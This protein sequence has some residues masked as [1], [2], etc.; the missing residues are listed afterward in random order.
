[1][2][3]FDFSNPREPYD[4]RKKPLKMQEVFE[5]SKDYCLN[6]DDL[7]MRYNIFTTPPQDCKRGQYKEKQNIEKTLTHLSVRPNEVV[8]TT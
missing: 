1:M 2:N 4:I 8:I 3:T 5:N 6:K 7:R